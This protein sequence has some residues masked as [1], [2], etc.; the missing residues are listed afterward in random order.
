MI[1]FSVLMSLYYKETPQFLDSC[2]ES[3]WNKQ[4]LKPNEMVLVLDGAIG[5]GLTKIIN[6]WQ[7]KE[8]C[9]IKIIELAK[10]VGLGKALNEGLKHCSHKWVFRMDTD[11]VCAPD[12]FEK[13]V[14]YIQNHPE[15][16]IFSSQVTEFDSNPNQP[17]ATKSVPI[18]HQAILEFSKK[19]CPF[20]HMAIA[21]KKSAI[22]AVGGYQHHLMMEDYNLWLRVLAAGYNSAN[23]PESLV[24]V[25]AGNAMIGRRRGWRYVKSEWQLFQ[26]KRTLNFQS[27]L[28]A[29][30][31]FLLRALPRL[32]P[33][34]VLKW[35]YKQLRK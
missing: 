13:Q 1:L 12:R 10:N 5:I 35:L 14:A 25:R 17:A 8:Y 4:S 31:V 20:N 16:D 23:L 29:F 11:D 6:K 32:L 24:Y 7:Y 2:L 3:I 15:I 19:R 26:L 9:H 33:E 18:T 30:S 34:K 28:P 27:F 21:Y 22:A